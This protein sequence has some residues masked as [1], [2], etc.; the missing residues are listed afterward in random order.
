MF[1]SPRIGERDRVRGEVRSNSAISGDR[2]RAL[3][4]SSTDAELR[5]WRLLRNRRLLPF[6]F[7]RQHPIDKYIVDFV[8]IEAKFVIELDGGQHSDQQEYDG[9]RTGVLEEA[10]YRVL[11]FWNNDVLNN[12][13]S[14]MAVIYKELG[15]PQS[16]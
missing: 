1:P 15:C 10:G 3:R 6:K 14:V 5:L 12:S 16:P 9:V 7:R 8:C 4:E 13:D 2:A 11:R